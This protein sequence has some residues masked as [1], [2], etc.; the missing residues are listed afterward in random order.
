MKANS[1]AEN[2]MG[3]LPP[4]IDTY[5]DEKPIDYISLRGLSKASFTAT[6]CEDA[7]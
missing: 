3:S 7:A 1:R 2:A 6:T 5:I 4:R